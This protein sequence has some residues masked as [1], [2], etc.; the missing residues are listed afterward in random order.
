MAKTETF[1]APALTRSW[2]PPL[3]GGT[4]LMAAVD[5][6]HGVLRALSLD[7]DR[8][9]QLQHRDDRRAGSLRPGGMAQSLRRARH[10]ALALGT[11]SRSVSCCSW[12]PCRPA[13]LFH[14]CWRAPISSVPICLSLVSGFRS[15]CPAWRLH[16]RLDADARSEHR[17][18]QFLV[19]PG[20]G[21]ERAQFRYLFFLGNHLGPRGEPRA[22][23][24]GHAA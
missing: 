22:V 15:S 7:A 12:S 8:H 23:D 21:F 11:A 4:A 19:A 1:D 16:L 5:R 2:L 17:P 6:L 24:Q 10:L 18:D 20:A 9:Q 13:S 3:D 14:G